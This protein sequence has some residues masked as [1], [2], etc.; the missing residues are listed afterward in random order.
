MNAEHAH[1]HL[2]ACRYRK[3]GLVCSLCGESERRLMA[4]ERVEAR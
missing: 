4:A 2:A 1:I 3:Q